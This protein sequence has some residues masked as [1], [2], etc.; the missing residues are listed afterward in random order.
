MEIAVDGIRVS[1]GDWEAIRKVPAGDLPPLT[2]PQREVARKLG[3]PEQDYARSALAGERTQESLLRKTERFATLLQRRLA[4]IAPGAT[5]SRVTLRTL[6]DRFDVE[7]AV[8]NSTLPLRID[9]HVVDDLFERGSADA[10]QRLH[11][12]LSTVSVL[13]H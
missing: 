10:E 4:E 11:R 1:P 2:P 3:I 8:N 6:N 5:V 7:V 9:E 12:I 13:R